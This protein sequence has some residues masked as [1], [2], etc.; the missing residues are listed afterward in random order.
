MSTKADILIEGEQQYYIYVCCDGYP[1]GVIPVIKPLVKEYFSKNR[2]KSLLEFMSN[3]LNIK[4]TDEKYNNGFGIH[5]IKIDGRNPWRQ[6]SYHILKD[7]KIQVYDVYENNI[8]TICMEK[9]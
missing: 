1:S 2:R 4:I 6:F 7:G 3:K 5:D 9:E 8:E